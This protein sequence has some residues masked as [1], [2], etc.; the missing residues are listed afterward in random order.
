MKSNSLK[1]EKPNYA[2]DAFDVGRAAPAA[3]VVSVVAPVGQ[4]EGFFRSDNGQ[5]DPGT[6]LNA[7][8]ATA[9]VSRGSCLV[10]AAPDEVHD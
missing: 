7:D 4:F 8:G 2:T 10:W 9:G 3:V 6:S 1:R 5:S